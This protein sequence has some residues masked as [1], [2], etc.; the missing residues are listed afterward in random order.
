MYTKGRR[1]LGHV[2][3]FSRGDQQFTG[4][5]A[6][7]GAG[8]SMGTTLDEDNVVRA[9]LGGA[10]G[11]EPGRTRTDHGDFFLQM[12]HDRS[13]ASYFFIAL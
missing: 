13:L 5:T 8:G 9:F 11:G 6:H 7:P 2:G 10:I 12:S 3:R 4:H 1:S